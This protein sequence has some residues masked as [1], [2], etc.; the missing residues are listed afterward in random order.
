[1]INEY[2]TEIQTTK[3]ETTSASHG[4]VLHAWFPTQE[5]NLEPT[6]IVSRMAE[7]RKAG[8]TQNTIVTRL[9]VLHQLVRFIEDKEIVIPEVKA[10]RRIIKSVKPQ[11]KISPH[12]TTEQVEAVIEK[13]TDPKYQAIIAILFY[14]GLRVSE[15]VGLDGCD[16]LPNGQLHIRNTKNGEDRIIALHQNALKMLGRYLSQYRNPSNTHAIFTTAHGR[17]SINVVQRQVAKYSQEAGF[18]LSCHSFRRGAGT[19][20]AEQG[21]H[22]RAIQ[23]FLGHKSITTTQLYTHVT[24]TLRSQV[25]KAYDNARPVGQPKAQLGLFEE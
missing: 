19:F 3:A 4:R 10:L 6:F 11:K 13:I 14:G 12:A 20:L 23:D 1:M 9:N 15:V 18:D 21:V 25:T 8:I 16:L 22:M 17:I 5:M 2:L 7:W 24:D